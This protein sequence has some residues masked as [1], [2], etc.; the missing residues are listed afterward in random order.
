MTCMKIS[1]ADS[2]TFS[3]ILRKRVLISKLSSAL[4]SL[5]SRMT[6]QAA[7]DL[8]AMTIMEE[9]AQAEAGEAAP[10]VGT[11]V[12][13]ATE[14]A[15]AEAAIPEVEEA[16]IMARAPEEVAA[17]KAAIQEAAEAEAVMTLEALP[18][19]SEAAVEVALAEETTLVT[20]LIASVETEVAE[21]V[22]ATTMLAARRAAIEEEVA[23]AVASRSNPHL[24]VSREETE[25]VRLYTA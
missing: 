13:A 23:A 5:T 14:V 6:E 16:M 25:I 21:A 17:T 1:L 3:I 24:V 10:Q 18:E 7:G 9:A 15:A 8:R 20:H 2:W 22:E 11:R 12:I 4:S 19:V